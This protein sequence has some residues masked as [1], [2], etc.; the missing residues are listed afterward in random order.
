MELVNLQGRKVKALVKP[1][2]LKNYNE[3][4]THTIKEYKEEVKQTWE[5]RSVLS[6]KEQEDMEVHQ[7]MMKCYSVQV[8]KISIDKQ[9]NEEKENKG[10]LSMKLIIMEETIVIP[11]DNLWEEYD[12]LVTEA[13]NY[14]DK[15]GEE[16]TIYNL[17]KILEWLFLLNY[18]E[19][20]Q[21]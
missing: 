3:H 1:E 18:N 2:D 13:E 11:H 17:E 6:N 21:E 10:A 16:M 8:F 5:E 7:V 9:L 14:E 15:S 19:S 4:N 20:V 12:Q